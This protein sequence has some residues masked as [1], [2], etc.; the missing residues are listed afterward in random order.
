LICAVLFASCSVG[1]AAGATIWTVHPTD[2]GANFT[3]LQAAI[4]NAAA[5]DSIEV[6]NGTYNETVLVDKRLTIYSRDDPNVTIIDA[7]GSGS[8]I[9]LNADSCTIDGLKALGGGTSISYAAGIDIQS[10]GNLI[11]N[12]IC[13]NNSDGIRL[14]YSSDNT[15][16]NNTCC[17]N[18]KTDP[19][20]IALI[21]SSNNTISNNDFCK[22]NRNGVEMFHSP[23]NKIM[24]NQISENYLNGIKLTDSSNNL[25]SDN[26]I[27]GNEEDGIESI[28]SSNILLSS[29]EICGNKG[30][31]V[32]SLFSLYITIS[33]CDV[34]DNNR[35]GIV[36]SNSTTNRISS[37]KIHDNWY[38]IVLA[39][40]TDNI[41]VNNEI[42][43]NDEEGIY[44]ES[45]SSSNLVYYNDF[46]NNGPNVESQDSDNFWNS[47]AMINYTYNSSQYLNYTGNH[48]SDYSGADNND[49]GIDD[50]PYSIDESNGKGEA[51]DFDYYPLIRPIRFYLVENTPPVADFAFSPPAPFVNETITFDASTSYDPDGVI[52]LYQWD[53]GDGNNESTA[54]RIIT[55]NYSSAA[56]YTVTLTV[57]DD[58][59]ATTSTS[60]LLTIRP[61]LFPVHNLN[62]L[63]NFSTI[64]A[65]IYDSDTEPGDVIEVDPGTYTENVKVN[66]SLT[67]RSS[68]GNSAD[69][70][71]SAADPNDHTFEV[72]AAYVNISGLTITGA[73]NNEKAGIYLDGIVFCSISSNNITEN[74]YGTYLT[75]SSANNVSTNTFSSS[76]TW[77]I[78]IINSEGNSFLHN[79]FS[80]TTI[81]FTYAGDIAARGVESPAPDPF[82]YRNI[83][84][85]VN[86]TNISANSWLLLNVYYTDTDLGSVEEPSLR[87]F[88]YNGTDWVLVPEPNSVNIAENYVYANITS[89]SIFAPMGLPLPPVQNINT[90][91]NFSSI[92][93]AIDAPNTTNGHI[94]E[95]APG[96]FTENVKVNKSLTIRSFY[97]NPLTTIVQASNPSDHV[98]N[99]TADYVNISGFTI[100]NATVNA[101][102]IYAY[103]SSNNTMTNNIIISNLCGMFLQASNYNNLSNNFVCSNSANGIYL[104]YGEGNSIIDNILSYN[105]YNGLNAEYANNNQILNNSANFNEM[106]EGI[107][108]I[109]SNSNII[110]N[111]TAISNFDNGILLYNSNFNNIA[112]NNASFTIHWNG[113]C[114]SSSRENTLANNTANSNGGSGFALFSSSNRNTITTNTANCNRVGLQLS[115]YGGSF[116]TITNNNFDSNYDGINLWYFSDNN[117][118]ANNSVNFNYDGG[119]YLITSSNNSIENNN[120]SYT[121]LWNGI[122]LWYNSQNNTINNNTVNA[123]GALGIGL[124]GS[125]SY[126]I[127][128]NNTACFSKRYY[129]IQLTDSASYNIITNNNASFNRF[130]GIALYR[131]S[132]NNTI[133]NNDLVSNMGGLRLD[134]SKGILCDN[135]ITENEIFLSKSY[136]MYLENLRY[137]NNISN[138]N[139][140]NNGLFGIWAINTSN[141]SINSNT[142]NL[143][144]RG[145]GLDQSSDIQVIHND[146]NTNKISGISLLNST[147]NTLIGNMAR[148]N[149][150]EGIHLSN[151]SSNNISTNDVSGSPELYSYFG[152][153]LYSSNDNDIIDNNAGSNYYFGV[154]NYSSFSRINNSGTVYNQSKEIRGVRV[155][156]LETLTPS[157]QSVDNT[158]NA[159][160]SILVENLGNVPDTFNLVA[161]STDNPEVLSLDADTVTLGPGEGSGRVIEDEF[162]TVQLNVTDSTPGIYRVKVEAIADSPVWGRDETVKD[163]SETWTIVQGRMGSGTEINS[164]IIESALIDSSLTDSTVNRSAIIISTISG[165]T[166]TSSIIKNSTIIETD[167]SDIMT[168][169][170]ASMLY[171]EDAMVNNG[172]ISRG[173]ITIG[174]PG[175]SFVIRNEIPISELVIGTDHFDSNLVGLTYVKSDKSLTVDGE[176][177]D[178]GF[179][180]YAGDNYFAGSLSV[181]R[182]RIPPFGFKECDNNMGGYEFVEVSENVEGSTDL[183]VIKVFYDATLPSE[184]I[185]SLTLVC[186]NENTAKWEPI[187]D[188]GIN[189]AGKYVWGN[190]SH[191]S[192]FA[193]IVQPPVLKPLGPGLAVVTGGGRGPSP[194][195]IAILIASPGTNFFHFEWLGLDILSVATD[196]KNVAMN[197]KV[198]LKR[199]DKPVEISDCPGSVYGYYDISTNLESENLDSVTINFRVSKVWTVLN[200]LSVESIKLY[201]YAKSWE[202]LKTSKFTEDNDYIYFS[203]ESPDLS[204][205]AIAGKKK[206]AQIAPLTSPKAPPASAPMPPKSPP[207]PPFPLVPLV[208]VIAILTALIVV[209]VA[210]I[211][212]RRR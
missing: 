75:N 120:F 68:S 32:F 195:E 194:W 96:I 66:K 22:N 173:N 135:Q 58:A 184:V 26:R 94:L 7:R 174:S 95:V 71:V 141:L 126:N 19:N 86:A 6:W 92:Q 1:V 17:E 93:E 63:E 15:I 156:V 181:Q 132:N 137:F 74:S 165:S 54:E 82:G 123:N 199:T 210:Y 197:A 193:L 56:D 125:S 78:F 99:I 64:Q 51:D 50:V 34:H 114:L 136:G 166:I 20:G 191:Y 151:S 113:I 12:C 61:L 192:V 98:F 43:E 11:K 35:T 13:E 160:Y 162:K 182:S 41:I 172:N 149:T 207:T 161:S 109:S 186:Y 60:K 57:T 157:L 168:R 138:N 90:S 204:L 152:I 29:N 102:G 81:T 79:I 134:G 21:N 37:S 121:Q 211:L 116:N 118:I 212:L 53:F 24:D 140:S 144:E 176:N 145:I 187:P 107:Q 163:S 87:M 131:S 196:L 110:S 14:W 39:S 127:I 52:I 100:R 154:L 84:K 80:S 62:T 202:E 129:G 122:A 67:I 206:A 72:I 148:F 36:L 130:F 9:T 23:N 159:T 179:D 97:G 16:L 85:Y 115:S 101:A 2:P 201:R 40:A 88:T 104:S 143:N 76:A 171:L 155:Y 70:L 175:I 180:I 150:Y 117:V 164:T 28:E 48:W 112:N 69:T 147:N 190:R 105:K 200:D 106:W 65:A 25:I 128:T 111:N 33:N 203:A 31:G 119:M 55:H 38:G 45:N 108:L 124:F 91:E 46:V 170:N 139:L 4:T 47:S 188:S 49:D 89:F 8:A 42:K 59:S 10:N 167:L 18:T 209:A 103:N 153:A 185:N 189:F 183:V 27:C 30:H 178:T 177:S 142:V 44:F 205:F 3:S 5:G 198:G 169:L 158:T 73:N 83:G 146:A 208:A 77:D 133:Y